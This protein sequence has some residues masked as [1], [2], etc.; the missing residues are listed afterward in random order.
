MSYQQVRQLIDRVRDFSRRI[1][2]LCK[3]QQK[4]AGDERVK[5]ILEKTARRE[6]SLEQALRQYSA[7]GKDSVLDTWVQYT[8]EDD[9]RRALEESDL[10]ADMSVEEIIAAVQRFETALIDFYRQLSRS[11]SAESVSELFSRLAELEETEQ[12]RYS[13]DALDS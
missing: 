6:R 8:P 2:S 4:L 7:M 13:W 3:E 5:W 12:T 9:L 10:S 1:R 11:T